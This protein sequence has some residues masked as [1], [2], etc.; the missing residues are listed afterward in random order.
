[1]GRSTIFGADPDHEPDPGILMEFLSSQHAV[2]AGRDN[3]MANRSVC[4]SAC[5]VPVLCLNERTI[6]SYSLT[7]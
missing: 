7:I 4:P 2:N 3:V 5:P 1:M 6:S